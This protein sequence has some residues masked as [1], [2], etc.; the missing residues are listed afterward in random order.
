MLEPHLSNWRSNRHLQSWLPI[1]FTVFAALF[2]IPP[3]HAQT[4][5]TIA[6]PVDATATLEQA[7]PDLGERLVQES[8]GRVSL[9]PVTLAAETMRESVR[10]VHAGEVELA[11]LPIGE[12]IELNDKFAVFETPFMF[13]DLGAVDRFIETAEGRVV[14]NSLRE[15][16][17]VGLGLLHVDL[18]DLTGEGLATDP[19]SLRDKTLG[20]DERTGIEPFDALGTRSVSRPLPAFE[21]PFAAGRLDAVEVT[22]PGLIQSRAL[23]RRGRLFITDHRYDGW[24]LVANRGWLRG[25]A[26]AARDR[27]RATLRTWLSAQNSRTNERID[28]QL[29][30]IRDHVVLDFQD[31][32]R[33]REALAEPLARYEDLVGTDIIEAARRSNFVTQGQFSF[34]VRED[35]R[36]MDLQPVQQRVRRSQTPLPW[37]A[38]ANEDFTPVQL[39]FGTDR[40]H[41]GPEDDLTFTGDRARTLKLGSV[42]VTVPKTHNLGEIERPSSYLWG[43]VT[44]SEDEREHIVMRKPALLS[45]DEFA[46]DL[47][48]IVNRSTDRKQAFVFVHGFNV[49]FNE[50]AWRTAQFAYDLEFDGAATFYS[51]P[52]RGDPKAYVYDQ[53]SARQARD[54]LQE[55]LE[56]VRTES[57][58][59]IVHLIGHSMGTNP[60]MEAVSEMWEDK[61]A[62]DARPI[63]NQII[64][65]AADIDRDVFFD[66]AEQVDG[67]AEALTLYA[68]A[69]DRALQLS[70]AIRL[71][72]A[73]RAGHVSENGP[74]VHEAVDTIDATDLNTSYFAL[75]HS[76][77]AEHAE[78]MSDIG[79][80]F[81][82]GTR[83]PDARTEKMMP[84][85]GEGERTYWVYQP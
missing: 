59:E 66:L 62:E 16:G 55:F 83:P 19:R 46:A 73:F 20:V 37:D 6:H 23:Q 69:K 56:L 1:F 74:T 60:L 65:A 64:L 44:L 4:T 50:A 45:R 84:M 38:G 29:V 17:L 14:L 68:S 10:L 26:D 21:T 71:G 22:V 24:V 47:R 77:Y 54:T 82:D 34:V 61:P 43:L 49:S 52:S 32:E 58:A 75:G 57:G 51:W 63:F 15:Y 72:S 48:A 27:L 18:R 8:D 39:F 28:E 25:L 12:A 67:A 53:D 36:P 79:K 42:I 40:E 30:R 13:N 80:L 31:K 85:P 41:R 9:E 11:L 7:L 76:D 2:L 78:L 33:W 70:E 3:A 35:P 81:S 5:L